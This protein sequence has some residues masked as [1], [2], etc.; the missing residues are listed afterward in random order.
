[1]AAYLKEVMKQI[2]KVIFYYFPEYL[3]ELGWE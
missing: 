3:I 2:H 1:M